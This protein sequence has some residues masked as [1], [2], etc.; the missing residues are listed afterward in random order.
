MADEGDGKCVVQERDEPGDDDRF[1]QNHERRTGKSSLQFHGQNAK[2]RLEV[3]PQRRPLRKAHALCF[4]ELKEMEGDESK[5]G[6]FH[7]KLQISFY[8][9]RDV[10][11]EYTREGEGHGEEGWIINIPVG[12]T[13]LYRFQ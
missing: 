10:A 2:A 13:E 6:T 7:A 9:G 5:V 11:A 3:S 8:V 12:V 1:A 4:K